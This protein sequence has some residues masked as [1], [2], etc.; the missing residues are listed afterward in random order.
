RFNYA[1]DIYPVNPKQDQ[2]DGLPCV[3]S[4]ADL[5]KGVDAAII[6]IPQAGVEDALRQAIARDLGGAVLFSAGYAETGPE[7]R[8]AQD[9]LTRMAKEGGLALAGPNC[10]GLVNYDGGVP[11]TSGPVVPVD[12]RGR[13]GLAVLAQSGGMMG[14][15]VNAS[16]DRD[17]PLSYAISTGNEA[18]LSVT[19]YFEALVEDDA[20]GV[21]AIFAE[22]I[23]DTPRF[24]RTARRAYELGKP[25]ILLHSG[26]SVRAQEASLSHTGS[27][28]SNYAA[29][30]AAVKEAH[31]LLAD[32]MDALID[33]SELMSKFPRQPGKGLGIITDSGAFKSLAL[34]VAEDVG[35][36]LPKPA[37]NLRQRL[38]DVTF[39]FVEPDNP[40]DVTGQAMMDIERIYGDAATVLLEDP[41]IDAVLVCQMPGAPRVVE[42]KA[43]AVVEISRKL[44]AP[45]GCVFIGSGAPMPEAAKAALAEAS[46]PLFQSGERAIRALA[47][48]MQFGAGH[49]VAQTTVEMPPQSLPHGGVIAEHEAKDWLRKVIGLK[50]PAGVM[51]TSEDEATQGADTLGYPV[52]MKVQHAQL[53]HKSDVGGVLVGLKDAQAVRDGWHCIQANVQ[54]ARPGQTID[55]ILIEK[56]G[57]PG[58]ELV[59]GAKRDDQWG[60]MIMVGLGGVW[61]E[62]LKDV[63]LVPAGAGAD[64][65][66]RA[67]L[68]LRGAK[69]LTGYRGVPPVDLDAAADLAAKLGALMLACPQIQEID[70]NP[71]LA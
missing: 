15:L 14:C 51:A 47:T 65:M 16:E 11:L 52:V 53:A 38:R 1:G 30:E 26:R 39:D 54:A 17:I 36:N 57:A 67:L 45:V 25:V 62:V 22:Q 43:R 63:K 46:V 70:L 12:R 2:I 20:N 4:V 9:R 8:A 23:K 68:S 35:L 55:G 42:A 40:L 37:A 69:L 13:R 5:P 31:I 50:T 58:L 64:A 66:K 18:V 59:I 32:G 48:V 19:D 61:I 56:M 60:P 7:G 6:A 44:D 34:D 29:M 33:I 28:A 71:V 49:G 21:F 10:L 3:A 24:L 27:V 41:E